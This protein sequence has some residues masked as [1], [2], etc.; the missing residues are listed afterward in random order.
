MDIPWRCVFCHSVLFSRIIQK[1]YSWWVLNKNALKS[2]CRVRQWI[3]PSTNKK[4]KKGKRK[5]KKRKEKHKKNSLQ[6]ENRTKQEFDGKKLRSIEMRRNKWMNEIRRRN[7]C[8]L[9]VCLLE[10][11]NLF[12]YS[13]ILIICV[14]CVNAHYTSAEYPVVSQ[15]ITVKYSYIFAFIVISS[16]V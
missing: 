11:E 5:G 4:Q 15:T 3:L 16:S 14:I 9:C 12:L 8:A 7:R 10:N 6:T 1:Y 13:F 2:R